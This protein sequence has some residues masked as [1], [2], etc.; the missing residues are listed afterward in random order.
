M[1]QQAL[2]LTLLFTGLIH[3]VRLDRVS[4]YLTVV[5]ASADNDSR[6][7]FRVFRNEHSPLTCKTADSPCL[8]ILNVPLWH[9]LVRLSLV[10]VAEQR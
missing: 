3:S 1:I 6:I 5:L 10:D 8:P 4:N 9:H 7:S 2:P